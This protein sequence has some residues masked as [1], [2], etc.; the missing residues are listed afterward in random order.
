MKSQSALCSKKEIADAIE[1]L[2]HT[3]CNFEG[4]FRTD[5]PLM[6][7]LWLT[8][9]FVL[10]V[11]SLNA[12]LKNGNMFFVHVGANNFE[13]FGRDEDYNVAAKRFTFQAKVYLMSKKTPY[14]GFKFTGGFYTLGIDEEYY[15]ERFGNPTHNSFESETRFNPILTVGPVVFIRSKVVDICIE[16]A[17]GIVG[18][19]SPNLTHIYQDENVISKETRSYKSAKTA[20][21]ATVGLGLYRKIT[22]KI[23]V[24]LSADYAFAKSYKTK[25]IEEY[26][27]ES[28]DGIPT[29]NSVSSN[30][31]TRSSKEGLI[32][33]VGVGFYLPEGKS[34]KAD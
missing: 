2:S 32:F 12:Q 29:T 30:I 18:A 25:R 11:S 17:V 8:V 22:D 21:A 5:L 13:E 15:A 24:S 7:N 28:D 10:A 27:L 34:A 19:L 20:I 14:V 31:P 33:S 26:R 1:Q 16:P 6:K 4:I 23:V 3:K 9:F